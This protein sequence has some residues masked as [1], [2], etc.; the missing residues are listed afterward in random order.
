MLGSILS[1]C[2][3]LAYGTDVFG[4]ILSVDG[5]NQLFELVAF[6]HNFDDN[7]KCWETILIIKGLTDNAETKI[8]DS[9][10]V[11]R[12]MTPHDIAE[13]KIKQLSR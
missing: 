10:T 6:T 4:N 1:N 5:C 7:K 2:I 13:W 11:K 9:P 3:F 8:T 12:N